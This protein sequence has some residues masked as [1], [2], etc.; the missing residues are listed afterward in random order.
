MIGVAGLALG[1]FISTFLRLVEKFFERSRLEP[2]EKGQRPFKQFPS[3]QK[4]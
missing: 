3:L 1:G 4:F 2:S